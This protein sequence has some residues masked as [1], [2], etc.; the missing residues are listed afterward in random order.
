MLVSGGQIL[1][2]DRVYTDDTLSGDGVKH[3]LGISTDVKA[4]INSISSCVTSAHVDFEQG[5]AYVLESTDDGVAWSGIDLSSLGKMYNISS[6]TPD[7]VFAGIS[8]DVQNNPLYVI[9][10]ASASE[11][12]QQIIITEETEPTSI[13]P[14]VVGVHIETSSSSYSADTDYATKN[15]VSENFI[16]DAPL[17]NKIY[18]RKNGTWVQVEGGSSA[19]PF[20]IEINDDT[21]E[22]DTKFADVMRA[23]E[24]NLPIRLTSKD[25]AI[26]YIQ[27]YYFDET[28]IEL[29][30]F[31]NG[32]YGILS[33]DADDEWDIEIKELP[34]LDELPIFVI[35]YNRTTYSEIEDAYDQGFAFFFNDDVSN[36]LIPVTVEESDYDPGRKGSAS[37]YKITGVYNKQYF[38]I[39][40]GKH[41][42][43]IERTNSLVFD[44]PSDDTLYARKNGNWEEIEID[45]E[46]TT[47]AEINE[48]LGGLT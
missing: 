8:A 33:V 26:F 38:E 48:I 10:A 21:M 40:V 6:L 37:S 3:N 5:L 20:D 17:D 41:G 2:I 31:S 39:F 36:T 29:I 43:W 11:A 28:S 46:Y 4:A 44:A 22:I 35:N 12:K 45:L 42:D 18:G 32:M 1:A 7:T 13:D 30:I 9:S 24:A 19:E 47:S 16:G 34:N 27:S 23:I 15:W 14:H 25:G